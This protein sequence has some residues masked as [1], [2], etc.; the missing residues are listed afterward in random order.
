MRIFK[1][2]SIR[3]IEKMEER[4]DVNGLIKA[5]IHKNPEIRKLAASAL[6]SY[7]IRDAR[8]VEPL[9]TLLNDEDLETRKQAATTLG[10][11]GRAKAVGPLIEALK[12]IN[13]GIREDA[14]YALGSI[15]NK[16]AVEPLIETLKDVDYDLLIYAIGALEELGDK[17]AIEPLFDTLRDED[18]SFSA[19]QA[20]VKMEDESAMNF[21]CRSLTE[22][23]NPKIQLS[24]AEELIKI[25]NERA[26]EPLIQYL[27]DKDTKTH[28]AILEVFANISH[29]EGKINKKFDP[30][31]KVVANSQNIPIDKKP[32][33]TIYEG[34]NVSKL[35]ERVRNVALPQT[36]ILTESQINS[37]YS[38]IREEWGTN[39]YKG[40]VKD[41][42][43]ALRPRLKNDL[44]DSEFN[45]FRVQILYTQKCSQVESH[46]KGTFKGYRIW[47]ADNNLFFCFSS[48]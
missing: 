20:L 30:V 21:L 6:G 10:Y 26:V 31:Y 39:L 47:C 34:R 43:N 16:R 24:V 23:F 8:A 36:P 4:K 25:G 29:W 42:V 46:F 37:E 1:K 44:A 33:E 40:T 9:I 15:G 13:S 3:D 11:I 2:M 35:I 32:E 5:L 48:E 14:A 38:P 45:D 28:Q 22:D 7:D 27:N 41:L 18:L 12:D 17:R 19:L